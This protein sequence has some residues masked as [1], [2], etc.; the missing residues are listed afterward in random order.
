MNATEARIFGTAFDDLRKSFV[1]TIDSTVG[2]GP[3]MWDALDS[4]DA[5]ELMC[6]LARYNIRFTYVDDGGSAEVPR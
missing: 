5:F 3:A 1:K 2:N 4:Y 6:E